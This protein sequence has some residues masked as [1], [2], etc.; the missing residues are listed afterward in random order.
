MLA[1]DIRDANSILRAPFK[2]YS[3][4]LTYST[5]CRN[6]HVVEPL[7]ERYALSLAKNRRELEEALVSAESYMTINETL[8]EKAHRDAE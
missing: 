6:A 4:Y 3:S 7:K 8:V 2:F 5:H 1:Q